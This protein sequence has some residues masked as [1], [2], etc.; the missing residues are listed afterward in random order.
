M[1][2][3]IRR[4]DLIQFIPFLSSPRHACLLC[5][6][7]SERQVLR[8][9][10]KDMQPS[11]VTKMPYIPPY[12]CI[13]FADMRC[14]ILSGKSQQKK[15]RSVAHSRERCPSSQLPPKLRS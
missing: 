6:V 2:W 1:L 8:R 4:S 14:E 7:P 5:C 10:K 13:P 3:V 12:V 11:S 15:S 9:E